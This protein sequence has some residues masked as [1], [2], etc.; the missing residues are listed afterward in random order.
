MTG[1]F[2]WFSQLLGWGNILLTVAGLATLAVAAWAW[3]RERFQGLNEIERVGQKLIAKMEADG[4]RPDVVIGIGRGGAFT[5]G[6]LAGNFGTFPMELVE[7]MHEKNKTSPM[8]FINAEKKF[9]Y[10]RDAWPSGTKALVVEGASARGNTLREFRKLQELYLADWDCKYCVFFDN[11]SSNFEVDYA[12][13]VEDRV[14]QLYP[15]HKTD[16][17][18]NFLRKD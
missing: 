4:Y 12:G 16:K 14:R 6:W 1:I 7:R 8:T 10:L 2:E 18:R 15:W 3:F 13:L 17:Y 11:R 5:G 9:N